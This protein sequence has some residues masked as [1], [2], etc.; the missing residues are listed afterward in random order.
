MAKVY[1][2]HN[3]IISSLGFDSD[4]VVKNICNNI[5][6]LQRIDDKKILP[7]PFYSL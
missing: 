6:G 4:S 1:V 3:N 2:S 7:N 5:S